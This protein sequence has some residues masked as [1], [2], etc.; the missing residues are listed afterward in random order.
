MLQKKKEALNNQNK[1]EPQKK[2]VR[3]TTDRCLIG[4]HGHGGGGNKGLGGERGKK[5]AFIQL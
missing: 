5:N 2:L 3:M 1:S 4:S